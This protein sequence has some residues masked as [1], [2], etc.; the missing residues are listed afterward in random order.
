VTRT[1]PAEVANAAGTVFFGL[2]QTAKRLDR[3]MVSVES[4]EQGMHPMKQS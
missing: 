3:R 1:V 4:A 2:K